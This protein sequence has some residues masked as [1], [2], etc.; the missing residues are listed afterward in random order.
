M[1]DSPARSTPARSR[2]TAFEDG[3]A[4]GDR[5]PRH[6]S[7]APVLTRPDATRY[8]GAQKASREALRAGPRCVEADD[9]GDWP[10]GGKTAL[11]ERVITAQRLA[12][13]GPPP[14]I[15]AQLGASS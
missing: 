4:P 1:S 8:Q 5:R 7:R 6:S 13:Y 15:A 9:S 14:A 3:V 11:A 12:A 2:S 10:S